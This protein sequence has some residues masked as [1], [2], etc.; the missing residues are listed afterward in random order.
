[1]VPEPTAAPPLARDLA[2]FLTAFAAALQRAQMYPEGHPT[3]D[4][5][6]DQMLGVL[7]PMLAERP[8]ATFAVA[9]TRLF[10]GAAGSDPEHPLH[11]DMAGRLFRRNVGSI[12]LARGMTRQEAVATL[13]VLT[14]DG[15]DLLPHRSSHVEVE[16]L[17][18]AG[19]TLDA[20]ER[21]PA[22][23]SGLSGAAIWPALAR[24]VLGGSA[25][26]DGAPAP[27]PENVALALDALAAEAG[28]DGA[29]I[30]YLHE[31]ADASR[32]RAAPQ[33]QQIRRQVTGLLKRLRPETIQRLLRRDL[34]EAGGHRLVHDLAGL[35]SAAGTLGVVRAAAA[36]EGREI[37]PPLDRLLGKLARHAEQ[38][39]AL[40][41]HLA[42]DQFFAV[43]GDLLT[44]WGSPGRALIEPMDH[45]PPP[46]VPGMSG[47]EA[48]R[49][50]PMRLVTM[51]LDMGALDAAAERAVGLLVSRGSVRPLVDLLPRLPADDALGGSYRPL[52]VRT[53]TLAAL[54]SA[55]PVDVEAIELLAPEVGTAAIPVLLDGLAGSEERSVRRRLLQLLAH[56]GNEVVPEVT[57]RLPGG[58]WYFQRNLLRLLQM[59]PDPPEESL[60]V[61]YS[62]HPDA[63]V[64]VEGFRLLMRH[65][66]ARAR[67]IVEGLSDPDISGVRVAVMAAGEDCP[68][69]AAPLLLRGLQ[70]GRIE[71][72]LVPSAIRALGPMVDLPEVAVVLL[73]HAG[74]KLPLLGWRVGAKSKESLAAL[75]AM[76]RHWRADPRCAALLARAGRHPDPEIREAVSA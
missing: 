64:R 45:L 6:V 53:E 37:S 63:R 52:V 10:V 32:D 4:R 49:S 29:V 57:R 68:A 40:S 7:T 19:L 16:P 62:R 30:Q 23:G 20:L 12:R 18:F 61:E 50:D 59:L 46:L 27:S 38:G 31:A 24:A 1:M 47:A 58:P 55:P 44:S 48:Y 39:P 11:R 14:R 42:E 72:G 43:V 3:L 73:S 2:G 66:Q 54:L 9:P 35:V 34:E 25:F 13:T 36:I 75:S 71:P 5:A 41:R 33:A 74:R 22:E 56:F 60:A 70:D 26:P 21:D 67:G 76:A 28:R 8:A 17:N 65:P 69:A 15:S 51:Q